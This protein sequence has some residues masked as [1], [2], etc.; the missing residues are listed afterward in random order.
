MILPEL[1]A[2]RS[3]RFL[4]QYYIITWILHELEAFICKALKGEA[5][6][7]YASPLITQ[8]MEASGSPIG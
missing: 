5:I 8:Q 6:V 1:I 3:P 7:N 2:G 4:I